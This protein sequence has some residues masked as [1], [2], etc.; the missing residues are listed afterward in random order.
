MAEGGRADLA[1]IR[2]VAAVADEEHAEFALGAFGRDIDLARRHV[3]AFGVELEVVDQRFHRLLH[4]AA[5]GRHDLAVEAGYLALGHFGEALLHDAHGL[6]HF[7]DANHEAI[8]AIALGTDRH[9]EIHAV[10]DVVR[11]R[12]ADIPWNAGGADHRARE[13]PGDRIVPR[14]EADIDV[15]LLE[16]AVVGDEADRIL[17][18]TRHPLV[19]PRADVGQQL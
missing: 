13:T 3:K 14:H 4:L 10:I 19:E 17:E 16:D 11:L 7:L 6:A 2:L 18:Q 15:A 8:I 9:L 1:A 5:L 12:L